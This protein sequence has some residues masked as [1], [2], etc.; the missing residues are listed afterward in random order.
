[1][2]GG[3]III[4]LKQC[5]RNQE[6]KGKLTVIV[7]VSHY[8]TASVLVADGEARAVRLDVTLGS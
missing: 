7:L 4:Y 6:Q 2:G 3:G 5:L 1:M 8:L